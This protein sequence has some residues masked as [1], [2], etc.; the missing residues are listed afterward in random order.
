[1]H[2]PNSQTC[3]PSTYY[4][5]PIQTLSNLIQLPIKCLPNHTQLHIISLSSFLYNFQTI[6]PTS[7]QTYYTISYSNYDPIFNQ[8]P[9]SIKLLIKFI[10]KILTQIPT[11]LLTRIPVQSPILFPT[12]ILPPNSYQIPTS[13]PLTFLP[14]FLYNN[15]FKPQSILSQTPNTQKYP[16]KFISNAYQHSYPPSYPNYYQLPIGIPILKSYQCHI[17]FQ[18]ISLY[19]LIPQL[20]YKLQPQFLPEPLSKFIPKFLSTSYHHHTYIHMCMPIQTFS[21]YYIRYIT[22]VIYIYISYNKSLS[23]THMHNRKLCNTV[24]IQTMYKQHIRH[25][26]EKKHMR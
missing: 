11:H 15:I 5:L 4:Q 7:Y 20:L 19:K 23:Y 25:Y 9:P 21:S 14:K 6:Y 3:P 2:T 18:P 8:H 13:L 1:M 22:C 10:Q 24:C 12:N 16:S 26:V 17:N